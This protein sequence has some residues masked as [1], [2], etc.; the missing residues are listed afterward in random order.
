MKIAGVDVVDTAKATFKQFREDDLQGRAAEVA[1]NLLFSIVP[2]L[3]F[4]TSLSGFI[5]RAAGTDDSMQRITNWL[6]DHMG[7]SQ[8]QAVRDPIEKVVQSSHGG[9]LSVGAVLALWGGKNAVAAIM[10][11]LNTAFDVEEAR[12]WPKRTGLAIGLT[13]GLGLA[14]AATS[15]IFLLGSGVAADVM[16]RI[17][18]GETW[19]S[20]WSIARW[21]VIAAI[22]VV[23]V[24]FLYWAAPNI[25]APFK[26]LTPGSVLTVV[27]W[28]IATLG[29][30]FYFGH[31][32]GYAGGA[33]GALG[34][35][36]A[37]LFWLD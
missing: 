37:F 15:A 20:F 6:F 24:S 25:D 35:V 11:A 22:L 31:F 29:L 3:I 27:V 21:P 9:L 36:L 33:Y 12:P 10:K 1:Y 14:V 19:R 4:L 26:W 17:G 5:A 23:A 16:A 28:A 2:L 7:T 32:A 18:L 13:I 30:G 34:G 8:A